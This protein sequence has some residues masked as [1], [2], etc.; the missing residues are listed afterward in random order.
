[1]KIVF[2]G[3]TLPR[4]RAKAILPDAQFL[5]PVTQGDIASICRVKAPESIGIIDGLFRKSLSVW[6]KE[7]LFALSLG[8]RVYGASSMGALRA[9]ECEPWG[10]KPIGKIAA[11]VKDGS[12]S[13]SDVA[14]AHG[15][16][17]HGFRPLSVPFC[18]VRATLEACQEISPERREV[19]AVA[20]REIFYAE[21]RWSDIAKAAGCTKEERTLLTN[22]LVDQKAADAEE[23]LTAMRQRSSRL[24]PQRLT[25][26]NIFESYGS[27]LHGNDVRLPCPD[28]KPRRAWEI[29]AANNWAL[30]QACDRILALECARMLGL[31]PI[32]R[33][34]VTAAY[35][36]EEFAELG[37]RLDLLPY[38]LD[39]F[40]LEER[41]LAQA[42][43]WVSATD[44]S[45]GNAPRILKYLRGSFIYERAKTREADAP[46]ATNILPS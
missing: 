28:R 32:A 42:R 39:R 22:H 44:C 46:A 30:P 25:A 33:A 14:L 11:W 29:A 8:T 19:I 2:L 13:D 15:D 23:M 40:L 21:R 18:N 20:A 17:E 7:I 31:E 36:Q 35:N 45:Y 27:V 4:A 26:F 24:E 9:V 41:M 38:E 3:P 6:H 5:A 1:M 34:A 10:A 16:A 12:L 43:A 37:R